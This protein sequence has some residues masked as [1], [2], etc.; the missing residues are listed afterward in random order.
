MN[1]LLRSKKKKKHKKAASTNDTIWLL[2]IAE[3]HSPI[4]AKV[5]ISKNR[6]IYEPTVSAIP[7][8]PTGLPNTH[9]IYTKITEGNKVIKSK[10]RT[11]KYLPS[12]ICRVLTGLVK[13]RDSIPL[14][15]S[16]EILRIVRAGTKKTNSHDE[17]RKKGSKSANPALKRL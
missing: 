9:S 2:P 11:P 3:A 14:R 7:K 10:K 15:F 17:R 1:M 6:A 4:A 12:T 5:A 8:L 13:S 16:S